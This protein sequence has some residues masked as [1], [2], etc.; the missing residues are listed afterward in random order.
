[1]IY[2]FTGAN[3]DGASP[4]AG[5]V[6]GKNGVLY[7]TTTFGGNATACHNPY[8]QASGCGTVFELTPPSTPGGVWTATILH[9]FTGPSGEGSLPGPLTASPVGVLYGPTWSGGT[10]G[11]GT[12]FAIQP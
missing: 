12:I 8:T 7:G 4:A 9:S 10:A 5:V 3:G 6:L 2:S 1:M 11:K